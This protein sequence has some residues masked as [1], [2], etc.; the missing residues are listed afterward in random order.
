MKIPQVFTLILFM[1]NDV[2]LIRTVSYFII[3]QFKSNIY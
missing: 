1:H 2:N 3:I